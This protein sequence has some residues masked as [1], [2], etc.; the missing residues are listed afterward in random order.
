[1]F[2]VIDRRNIQCKWASGDL[3]QD[4]ISEFRVQSYFT[5][6][7]LPPISSSWQQAPWDS[8]PVFFFQMN[9]YRHS[10]YVISSLTRGWVYH[11]QLLLVLAS[12]VFLKSKSCGAYNHILLSQIWDFPNL[13]CQVSVFISPRKR[14]AQLYLQTL[15]SFS[16]PPTTRRATVEVF[17]LAS[18]RGKKGTDVSLS[19]ML[20]S[21]VCRPVYLGIKP[22]LGLTTRFLLLSDSC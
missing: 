16:S 13:E 18:T 2:C 17:Q 4:G 20:R 10:P 14:V 9:T 11:L 6:G 19:L 15:G 5:T 22:H 12:A 7:G 1:M 21:T 8:Q 3:S